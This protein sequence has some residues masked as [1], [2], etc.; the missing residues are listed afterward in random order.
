MPNLRLHLCAWAPRAWESKGVLPFG[1]GMHCQ[2]AVGRTGA[3]PTL[4]AKAAGIQGL[5]VLQVSCDGFCLLTWTFEQACS[6]AAISTDLRMVWP[7][8]SCLMS[9]VQFLACLAHL[10]AV[11]TLL[12]L[13]QL[14]SSNVIYV[15]VPE[16]LLY[17]NFD[18]N[19]PPAA[20]W[21][22]CQEAAVMATWILVSSIWNF[23]LEKYM[24]ISG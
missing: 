8:G 23:N 2:T 1:S 6:I 4:P 10:T 11:A 18:V 17:L 3:V 13:L 14:A 12:T 22:H 16:L 15:C 20:S 24:N 7:C 21:V 19:V 9:Q 5:S